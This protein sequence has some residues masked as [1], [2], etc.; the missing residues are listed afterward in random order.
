MKIKLRPTRCRVK[1][2]IRTDLIYKAG[3]CVGHYARKRLT[4]KVGPA[5]FLP[6]TYQRES[7]ATIEKKLAAP[8]RQSS[9]S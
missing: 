8:L 4:G 2:C 1:G 9:P 7:I 5:T 3:L 6:K